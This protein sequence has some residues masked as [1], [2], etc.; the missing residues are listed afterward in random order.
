MSQGYRANGETLN[1]CR[2]FLQNSYSLVNWVGLLPETKE[3]VVSPS[4]S[5]IPMCHGNL[6]AHVLCSH[7]LNTPKIIKC[8]NS[9]HGVGDWRKSFV[10]KSTHSL[11]VQLA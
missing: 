9:E 5:K 3:K 7:F 11:L 4:N 6:S 10:V 2:M 8:S 1:D